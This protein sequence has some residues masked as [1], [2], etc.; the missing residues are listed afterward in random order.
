MDPY[1]HV[2][3][4]VQVKTLHVRKDLVTISAQTS[5][6]FRISLARYLGESGFSESN[7]RV[8]GANASAK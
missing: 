7:G 6:K 4:L 2:S 8:M 3:D 1:L 5:Y